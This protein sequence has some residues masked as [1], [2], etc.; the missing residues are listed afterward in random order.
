MKKNG[1]QIPDRFFITSSPL[2][3][4]ASGLADGRK[5]KKKREGKT[6][7]KRISFARQAARD[8]LQKPSAVVGMPRD[9]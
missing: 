5:K 4:S 6:S 2:R 9:E 1:H 7:R 8:L 3:V